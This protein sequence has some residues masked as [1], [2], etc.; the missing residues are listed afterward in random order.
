MHRAAKYS[1]AGIIY[2]LSGVVL[3]E[4]AIWWTYQAI[5]ASYSGTVP[6]PIC[7]IPFT[8]FIVLVPIGFALLIYSGYIFFSEYEIVS[9]K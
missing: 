2:I 1:I 8:G 7:P 3:D 9:K 4:F 5:L 6:P